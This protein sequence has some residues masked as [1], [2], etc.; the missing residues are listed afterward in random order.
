MNPVERI[1]LTE[2]RTRIRLLERTLCRPKPQGERMDVRSEYLML[3]D[4]EDAMTEVKAA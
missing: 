2:V 3:R 4:I 1:S